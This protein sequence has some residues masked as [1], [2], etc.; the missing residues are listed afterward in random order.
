MM[1]RLY[2]LIVCAALFSCT[3]ENSDE[4]FPYA[5][6]VLN[7]T[8]WTTEATATAQVHL[9][10]EIISFPAKVDSFDAT[11]GGSVAFND[12]PTITISPA[13]CNFQNG[14]VVTGRVRIEVIALRTKGDFVR[15]ARPT[16]S[17]NRL[18]ESGGAFYIR[19]TK[20]GQELSLSQSKPVTIKYR[21]PNPVKDMRVFYG[22]QNITQGSLGSIGG[23]TWIPAQDNSR[24]TT[25]ENRDSSGNTVRGYELISQRFRWVNCDYFIDTTQPRTRINAVL[26]P[27]FTNKNT[28]VFA[29]F[30]DRNIVVQLTPEFASRSFFAF[31]IP[32]GKNITLLSLSKIENDLYLSKVETSVTAGLTLHLKPE[33]KTKA[34]VIQFLESL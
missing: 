16:T 14:T 23:F 32:V 25:F 3:K 7:D 10:P 34:Q 2:I 24:V 4:F 22:E 28:T 12:G 29:V 27:T 18:L 30:K 19:A 11:A 17:Y 33:L 20:D 13:A 26:P 15:F 5:N 21:Y 31:N 6:N 1:K 9:I 8:A